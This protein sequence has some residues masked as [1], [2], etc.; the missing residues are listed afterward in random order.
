[1][2]T[3]V[4]KNITNADYHGGHGI[5]KSGLDLIGKSPLHY[6][7]AYLDPDRPER[8]ETPAMAL[9]TA[10]HS[11]VLEPD[12][13]ATDYV[14]LP[15]DAPRKPTSVQRN[16]KKPSDDTIAAINWWDAFN[17]EHKNRRIIDR[18]DYESIVTIQRNVRNH[19]AAKV[20]MTEGEAELSVYWTD[21]ETGVLC[22]CRPDFMSYKHNAMIDVK[23]TEDASPAAFQRS[24]F[25]YG[26]HV[27]AAWYLDG[28]TA[29]TG[30]APKAFVFA[31]FEKS[32]PHATAF[33][34]AD[35]DMI[36]IGRKLYRERLA[37]YAQCLASNRW[38][39]YPDNLQAISLPVWALRAAND[40][41]Q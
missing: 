20:L 39:G 29:A 25:N 5:S 26:Y 7:A 13:F 10:I 34:Y 22:K 19:P 28:F 32:R 36:E 4:F 18:E 17:D 15:A 31:A 6:W 16:A 23:S 11:A 8:D 1:M 38:H 37:I 12:S 14:V 30:T 35:N 33:Y 3:G 24:I 27:Q 2:E 41:S 9:G 21:A 40:N